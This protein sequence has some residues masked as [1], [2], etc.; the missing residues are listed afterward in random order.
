MFDIEDLAL[1][2]GEI[3]NARR[4]TQFPP[5]LLKTKHLHWVWESQSEANKSQ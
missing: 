5:K 4:Q 3:K 1:R 2:R